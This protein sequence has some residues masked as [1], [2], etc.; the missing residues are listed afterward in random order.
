VGP[1]VEVAAAQA[2][3]SFSIALT[4]VRRIRV[5]ALTCSTDMPAS[6]R[7]AARAWPMDNGISFGEVSAN[8]A[9]GEPKTDDRRGDKEKSRTA[10]G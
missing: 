1:G 10:N 8:R 9:G 4:I 7:A 5:A 3:S 2:K 6:R